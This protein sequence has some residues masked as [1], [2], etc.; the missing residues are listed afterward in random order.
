MCP[1]HF[2][3]HFGHFF[4]CLLCCQLAQV[5]TNPPSLG[6]LL[7]QAV[8]RMRMVAL[9]PGFVLARNGCG[10]VQGS[11]R[12]PWSPAHLGWPCCSSIALLPSLALLL[13]P[14]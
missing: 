12:M 7:L 9:S 6:W 11:H 5:R 2:E 10:S 4:W 1:E 13:L 14:Q 8:P 3:M